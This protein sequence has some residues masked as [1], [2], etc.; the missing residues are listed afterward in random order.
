[1]NIASFF[2][3]HRAQSTKTQLLSRA[4]TSGWVVRAI[5]SGCQ[6]E[7]CV[8]HA[9][10]GHECNITGATLI[11]IVSIDRP[12]RGTEQHAEPQDL[13]NRGGINIEPQDCCI[14]LLTICR[15]KMNAVKCSVNSPCTKIRKSSKASIILLWIDVQFRW[16]LNFSMRSVSAKKIIQ[17]H[18]K[19]APFCG[20]VAR[21]IS[22]QPPC[23]M[24]RTM[25]FEIEMVLEFEHCIW[26]A[27]PISGHL[28]STFVIVK[29]LVR[30]ST[31]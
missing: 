10:C 4:R 14:S 28:I 15:N 3:Q 29:L 1:M 9:G 17:F 12:R 22:M 7:T 11:T 8:L 20:E 5:I 6:A 13:S 31:A 21:C 19:N 16:F 25:N 24:D 30:N 18:T 2:S 27:N 23:H 26:D